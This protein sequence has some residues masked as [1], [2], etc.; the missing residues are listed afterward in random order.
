MADKHAGTTTANV[1]GCAPVWIMP[2]SGAGW[3][4]RF[5]WIKK[6]SRTTTLV[7]MGLHLGFMGIAPLV[8]C[9]DCSARNTPNLFSAAKG[10]EIRFFL[11]SL[12]KAV[13]RR[14]DAY[15]AVRH[16]VQP[17]IRPQGVGGGVDQ[18]KRHGV[19]FIS[20]FPK[21]MASL[22]GTYCLVGKRG[23]RGDP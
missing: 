17:D 9:L 12:P 10:K 7:R 23:E 21:N 5:S 14:A 8:S 18:G 20:W 11:K 16:T 1:E 15:G 6:T 3:N 4:P 13:H 19:T 2:D 22:C